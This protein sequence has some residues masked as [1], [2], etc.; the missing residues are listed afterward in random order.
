[1]I[2]SRR[3]KGYLQKMDREKKLRMDPKRERPFLSSF[4]EHKKQEVLLYEKE[5]RFFMFKKVNLM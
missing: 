5:H 1:M 2:E 4:E 3:Q